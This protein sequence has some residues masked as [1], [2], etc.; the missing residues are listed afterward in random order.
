[1]FVIVWVCVCYCG[2]VVFVIVRG[3]CLLLCGVVFVI[4]RGCFCYCEGV[5]FVI[6]RGLCLLLWGLLCIEMILTVI[7]EGISKAATV[8]SVLMK[9]YTITCHDRGHFN[10]MLVLQSCTDSLHILPSLPGDR[11]ATSSDCMYHIGNMKVEEDVDMQGDEE[12]VNVKA[13][14]DIRC[15]EE[16]CIVVKDEEEKEEN[17]DIKE[18]EDVGIIEEVSL[19]GT[20]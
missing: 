13:E 3:L 20:V 11:N 15:E 2:G 1:M 12:E 16:E 17:I 10:V 7:M 8:L 19:Q 9:V 4:M 5:V 14:K 6:V 18:E